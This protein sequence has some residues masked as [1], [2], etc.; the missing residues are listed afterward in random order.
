MK[1]EKRISS[2]KRATISLSSLS[3]GSLFRTGYSSLVTVKSEKMWLPG[4]IEKTL[5]TPLHLVLVDEF[6]MST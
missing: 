4:L 3:S 5:E 6:Q 1:A 2:I